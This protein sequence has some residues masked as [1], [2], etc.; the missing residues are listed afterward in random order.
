[1]DAI[2]TATLFSALLTKRELQ[3][4]CLRL[5]VAVH[6]ALAYCT[7][8]G[9]P[10]EDFASKVFDD[11]GRGAC[12]RSED[13][14]EDVFV[15]LVHTPNGNF[16]VLEGIREGTNFYL[17]VV[18]NVMYDLPDEHH[19][20]RLRQAVEGLLRLSDAIAERAELIEHS[21]GKEFP[22]NDLPNAL[23]DE[24][25]A[26]CS[27]VCFSHDELESLR[28]DQSLLTDFAFRLAEAANLREQSIGHTDLERYP[29]AL[30]ADSICVLL[31]SAISTAITRC[32]IETTVKSSV[33]SFEH[34]LVKEFSRLFSTIPVLG[35]GPLPHLPFRRLKGGF[36]ASTIKQIDSGRYLQLVFHIDDLLGFQEAGLSG[37]NSEPRHLSLAIQTLVDIAASNAVTRPGFRDGLTLLVNCGYGR[38]FATSIRTLPERWRLVLLCYKALI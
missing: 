20:N 22:L 32:V 19:Y 5:E 14:A 35:E 37:F 15:G 17:Q 9:K 27:L 38:G 26:L 16:R 21:L 12:G 28:I 31:P 33:V 36:V 25:H 3:A 11:L 4:N 6:L 23:A 8:R 2:E 1:L 7:G 34:A 29:I 18:L 24:L 30:K 10:S 13:P